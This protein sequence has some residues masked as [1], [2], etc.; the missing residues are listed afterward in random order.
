MKSKLSKLHNYFINENY[1]TKRLFD[2]FPN[3]Y[4]LYGGAITDY[5]IDNPQT[6]DYDSV[7]LNERWPDAV[8]FLMK[9]HK[10]E[11]K[12]IYKKVQIQGKNWRDS[13]DHNNEPRWSEG[14][15][16]WSVQ[17]IPAS[18]VDVKWDPITKKW[19]KPFVS[20]IKVNHS[21]A[22]S[23]VNSVD[24]VTNRVAITKNEIVEFDDRWKET[25][26]WRTLEYDGWC[27][28]PSAALDRCHRYERV[29]GFN[30]S[31]TLRNSLHDLR[32]YRIEKQDVIKPEDFGEYKVDSYLDLKLELDD[33]R[34]H[35][36]NNLELPKRY[37]IDYHYND[38]GIIKGD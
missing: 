17:L 16:N 20:F 26:E 32:K 27:V 1:I 5:L 14:H 2:A 10:N 9:Q 8:E 11:V 21:S 4:V 36:K 35:Q 38:S 30:I 37:R 34:Y 33:I 6:L 7:L 31:D 25:I 19:L 24:C 3:D 13:F 12:W 29:K 18:S 23:V 28:D 22:E 15:N